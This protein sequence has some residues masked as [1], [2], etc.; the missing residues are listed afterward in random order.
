MQYCTVSGFAHNNPFQTEDRI[1]TYQKI[2]VLAEL[3]KLAAGKSTKSPVSLIA[4]LAIPRVLAGLR[5]HDVDALELLYRLDD[6][7]V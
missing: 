2:S 3:R 7:R 5:E 6:P 1:V 4:E